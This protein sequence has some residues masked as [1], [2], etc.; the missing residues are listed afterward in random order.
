VPFVIPI[1][2]AERFLGEATESVLAQTYDRWELLLV[3]D[4]STDAS[5]AI[6]R[7][8]PPLVADSVAGS[9]DDC[10]SLGGLAAAAILSEYQP[11]RGRRHPR[12]RTGHAC[13]R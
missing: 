7:R 6:A 9:R 3:D 12:M 11:L 4:G 8:R 10:G 1:W 13:S 5:P 2:N